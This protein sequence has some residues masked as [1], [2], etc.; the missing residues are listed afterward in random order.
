MPWLCTPR[1]SV[2]V[3][4]SAMSAASG[5]L[6]PAFWKSS[7]TNC[8]RAV[9]GRKMPPDG[10]AL[11][12]AIFILVCYFMLFSAIIAGGKFEL[13]E[14]RVKMICGINAVVWGLPARA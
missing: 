11:L 10:G 7:A 14:C 8:C 1:R 3:N 6:L 5:L 9:A 4:S 2:A 12:T 13:C